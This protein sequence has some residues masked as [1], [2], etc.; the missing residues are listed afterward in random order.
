M[1]IL[2]VKA[3]SL[4]DIIH[5]FSVVGY[6]HQKFP[7]AQ[8][9]WIVESSFADVVEAHPFVNRVYRVETKKWRKGR[10]WK[11]FW[12]VRKELRQNRYDVV[13]DLQG[14]FKSGLTTLQTKTKDKVGFGF[15]TVSEW[16]NLFVTN[17]KMNPP[18]GQNI[19]EDYLYLVQNYFGD[20]EKYQDGGVRLSLSFEQAK[21]IQSLLSHPALTNG[22]KVM[23]CPGS[24]WPNKQMTTLA[25]RD[26]LHKVQ[27]DT[28]CCY[29][30]VWG[31]DSERKMA[32]E[33][34]RG[35]QENSVIVDR[36]EI[37]VLQNL[38]DQL[39]L[40]IAMDSLPLHLAGTTST[41]TFSIFGPSS[42]IKYRPIGRH[43]H[44]FQGSCPY[45]KIFEKRCPLL[46]T[47]PTGACIR[48]LTGPE[49][50][51]N[52]ELKNILA[53]VFDD[54]RYTDRESKF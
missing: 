43:H 18:K 22:K 38:M 52:C 10:K 51:T 49:I 3:S 41:P 29:L 47:C 11:A 9:D 35:F 2:I 20:N 50:F 48:Y 54:Y 21:Q 39:D 42:A 5:T 36:L 16:P 7:K 26:F 15:K 1:K 12:Q 33:I 53:E 28:N 32:R 44:S 45:Q 17:V 8:I 14:N 40:V 13:F 30:L 19:R 25:L 27:E 31:N 24:A 6:L 34:H 46:R 4:G 37:A 23:V